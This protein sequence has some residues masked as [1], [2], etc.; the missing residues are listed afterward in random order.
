MEDFHRD[1]LKGPLWLRTTWLTVLLL[2]A[3]IATSLALLSNWA[4]DRV[5]ASLEARTSVERFYNAV[6][7]AERAQRAYVLTQDRDYLA[8]FNYAQIKA[9][10]LTDELGTIVARNRIELSE[11]GKLYELARE[12]NA[13]LAAAINLLHADGFEA[14][15]NSIR[16][17]EERQITRQILD[18]ALAIDKEENRVLASRERQARFLRSFLLGALILMIAGAL[19][20]STYSFDVQRR[21][22]QHL[23]HL[24]SNLEQKVEDRTNDLQMEKRRAEHLLEDISHRIG[25]NLA[26]ISSYLLLQA[27]RTNDE[28]ARDT[29]HDVHRRI[30]SVAT[31]QRRLHVNSA[32]TV[33]EI[34]PYLEAILND[35]RNNLAHD[36]VTLEVSATPLALRGADAVSVGVIVNELISNALKYAF[37]EGRGLVMVEITEKE[38]NVVLEITDDGCGFGD[39]AGRG[40][41]SLIVQSMVSA[42][43]GRSVRASAADDLQRPGTRWVIQFP[44]RVPPVTPQESGFDRSSG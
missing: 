9:G 25:N 19:L 26:M 27:K 29:L 5:R 15:V 44:Y 37:P 41:G 24:N 42:L 11:L 17:N 21:I 2:S 32:T 38:G 43:D 22:A 23:A 12:R 28:G 35:I 8:D 36:E 6:F 31:A 13:Q 30:V 33:V 3:G 34:K 7:E 20:I 10:Q 4:E 39:D 18:V 40:L 14:A 16:R 1:I